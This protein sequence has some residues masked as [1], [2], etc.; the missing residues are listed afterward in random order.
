MSDLKEQIVRCV[1]K[2]VER[3]NKAE[4]ERYKKLLDYV[5][6]KLLGQLE[7]ADTRALALL[8]DITDINYV[9]YR[10]HNVAAYHSWIRERN[11]FRLALE[12]LSDGPTYSPPV[13]ENEKCDSDIYSEI[14]ALADAFVNTLCEEAKQKINSRAAAK[15][16][17]VRAAAKKSLTR[18]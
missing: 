17:R 15:R 13:S 18:K 6:G 5:H 8:R 9:D 7:K 11:A 10:D 2:I 14:T 1:E 3:R 16:R 4:R 12:I